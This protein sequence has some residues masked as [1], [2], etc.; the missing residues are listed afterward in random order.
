MASN[1]ELKEHLRTALSYR[2][3]AQ[4]LQQESARA[5]SAG[6]IDNARYEHLS[7]FYT[8]HLRLAEKDLAYWR[9]EASA[10]REQLHSEYRQ[11]SRDL[12]R[13]RQGQ[14]EKRVSSER[15][16]DERARLEREISRH[17]AAIRELQQMG[18]AESSAVVGGYMDLPL[19]AYRG[20]EG[21]PPR[22]GKRGWRWT[23]ETIVFVL[24]CVLVGFA[25]LTAL[26]LFTDSDWSLWGSTPPKLECAFA[27][28]QQQEKSLQVACRNVGDR[29]IELYLPWP[30]AVP[31]GVEAD[32]TS[33]GGIEVQLRKPGEDSFHTYPVPSDWWIH[34]GRPVNAG[35]AVVVESLLT[36]QL[37]LDTAMVRSIEKGMEA[38]RV[39]VKRGDG[40]VFDSYERVFSESR[41]GAP[42]RTA[43]A[44]AAPEP[45]QAP[46]RGPDTPDEAVAPET[47]QESPEEREEAESK[48]PVSS[49]TPQERVSE[50]ETPPEPPVFAYVSFIGM[51]GE[52]AAL[53][54]QTPR[55]DRARRTMVEAGDEV[56]GG[57]LVEELN[58]DEQGVSLFHPSTGRTVQVMKGAAE[59]VR[60]TEAKR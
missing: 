38:I 37:E 32:N 10:R 45:P 43:P 36:A 56:G 12:E 2:E 51:V 46:E 18:K 47:P 14:A 1:A 39:V 44:E 19:E 15:V 23:W 20:K 25:V 35:E 17:A 6:N 16:V 24:A 53:S 49:E 52:K 58:Q 59:P 34:N 57:W 22:P 42:R 21:V 9:E 30:D 40:T 54:I 4:N 60:L 33:V 41:R 7:R 50:P 31:P 48:S 13:L 8:D 55:E 3:K 5:W 28:D 11:L 29:P 26:P 27:F